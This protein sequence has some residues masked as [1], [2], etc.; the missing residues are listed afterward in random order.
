MKTS[1][2]IRIRNHDWTRTI[3][4]AED[5]AKDN[6]KSDAVL[7]DHH[8]GWELIREAAHVSRIAY[9]AP[10]RSGWPT[11]SSLPD[12]PDDVTQ[13]QLM[14]AYL[15]GDLESLPSSETKPSRPSAE[16]IDRAEVILHLWHHYALARK[17]DRS[18]IKRAVYLKALGL[19]TLKIAGITG[20]TV[21][22]IRSA[23][24]E[25]A[26]DIVSQIDKYTKFCVD[27]SFS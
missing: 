20:L 2:E 4:D 6:K 22:Q 1:I 23:Q 7:K 18:R 5:T 11:T 12:A 26:Q 21:R 15:K 19:N 3:R 27:M 14:A 16:Q 24:V 10:P 8:I 25:A 9:P 17:G 13:W